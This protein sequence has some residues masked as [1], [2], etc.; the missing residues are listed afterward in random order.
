[1]ADGR[2]VGWGMGPSGPRE[3]SRYNRGDGSSNA[4]AFVFCS[5]WN[6]DSS[7]DQKGNKRDTLR[8]QLGHSGVGFFHSGE[9][10]NQRISVG[11]D[12]DA[13]PL[14]W[15]CRRFRLLTVHRGNRSGKNRP[16]SNKCCDTEPGVA[17]MLCRGKVGLLYTIHSPYRLKL[18]AS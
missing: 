14:G 15:I 11:G 9:L 4:V 17:A 8:L 1:M 3:R 5:R 2:T 12:P 18:P 10:A 13:A 16:K 6:G 7:Q